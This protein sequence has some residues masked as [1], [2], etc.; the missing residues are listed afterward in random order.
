[1]MCLIS[2]ALGTKRRHELEFDVFYRTYSIDVDVDVDL[3]PLESTL[4]MG[5]QYRF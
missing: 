1:M 4:S 3:E 5:Y 2:L